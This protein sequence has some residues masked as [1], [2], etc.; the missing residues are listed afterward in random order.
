[1]THLSPDS[2][3]SVIKCARNG[4]IRLLYHTSMHFDYIFVDVDAAAAAGVAGMSIGKELYGQH[5]HA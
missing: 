5:T 2:R 1:M 4:V 3:V